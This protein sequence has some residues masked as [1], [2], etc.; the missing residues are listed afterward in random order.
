MAGGFLLPLLPVLIPPLLQAPPLVLL[1]TRF[2]APG[3]S[4]RRLKPQKNAAGRGKSFFIDN[5][6]I[7]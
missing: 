7:N 4:A 1:G 5:I 2:F 6:S 3:P